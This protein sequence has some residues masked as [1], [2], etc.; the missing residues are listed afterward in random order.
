MKERSDR[1][2]ADE[3]RKDFEVE[4]CTLTYCI[5]KLCPELGD[6][7]QVLK[8]IALCMIGPANWVGADAPELAQVMNRPSAGGPTSELVIALS[9]A[10]GVR[11]EMRTHGYKEGY[12]RQRLAGVI[13]TR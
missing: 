6:Q 9:A 4:L 2:A 12:L 7:P 3:R 13:R 1:G 10:A 5:E 11:K 8:L